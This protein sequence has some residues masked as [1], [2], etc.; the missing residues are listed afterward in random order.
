MPWERQFLHIMVLEV[1]GAWEI[2][3]TFIFSTFCL[4]LFEEENFC[5]WLTPIFLPSLRL[6]WLGSLCDIVWKLTVRG[7]ECVFSPGVFFS[8]T[9]ASIDAKLVLVFRVSWSLYANYGKNDISLAGGGGGGGGGGCNHAW[10]DSSTR[11]RKSFVLAFDEPLSFKLRHFT[12][13]P[14]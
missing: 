13:I 5:A 3:S 11:V 9:C 12:E 14:I 7:G 10:L 4:G 8:S 1:D 2:A 6:F